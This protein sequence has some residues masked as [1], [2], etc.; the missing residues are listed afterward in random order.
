M[1]PESN[2]SALIN[3]SLM[4]PIINQ[5]II[6]GIAKTRKFDNIEDITVVN[7]VFRLVTDQTL[8]F[9][10]NYLRSLCKN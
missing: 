2:Q 4:E 3:L 9:I 5:P 6:N 10:T 7:L 1:K 8:I